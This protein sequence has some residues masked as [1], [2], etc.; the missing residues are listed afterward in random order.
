MIIFL[1]KY[2]LKTWKVKSRSE[3]NPDTGEPVYWKLELIGDG[4]ILCECP[5][6]YYKKNCFHITEKKK[7]LVAE[8]GSVEKAIQRYRMEKQLEYKE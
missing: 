1:G 2:P 6:G 7:E 5:R 8:F 3:R 4:R